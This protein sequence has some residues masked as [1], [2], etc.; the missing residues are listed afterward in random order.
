MVMVKDNQRDNPSVEVVVVV[1][2]LHLI[3]FLIVNSSEVKMVHL[4]KAHIY[5]LPFIRM[6]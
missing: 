1:V 5:P 2:P 6:N 4:E 3:T